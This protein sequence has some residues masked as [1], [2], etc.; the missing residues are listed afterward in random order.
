MN[1][2]FRNRGLVWSAAASWSVGGYWSHWEINAV[3]ALSFRFNSVDSSGQ[4]RVRV[5]NVD[6]MAGSSSGLDRGRWR[7]DW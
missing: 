4:S 5:R 6:W 1:R 3:Q 7:N 2:L